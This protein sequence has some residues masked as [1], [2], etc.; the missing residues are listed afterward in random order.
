MKIIYYEK[1]EENLVFL[2]KFQ[3]DYLERNLNI[4][5]YR[6]FNSS[7]DFLS[8][9]KVLTLGNLK[10]RLPYSSIKEI[11]ISYNYIKFIYPLILIAISGN[12]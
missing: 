5:Y 2:K 10:Y 3:K 12:I 11:D 7:N 1:V 9:S 8:K 6:A 4:E